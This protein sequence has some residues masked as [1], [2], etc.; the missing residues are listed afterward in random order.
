MSTE[1]KL[2]RDTFVARTEA[3]LRSMIFSGQ[4]RPGE[5]LNEVT[6]AATLGISRGP[7]REAVQRLG[8]QGILISQPHRGS[9]V[10]TFTRAEIVELYEM[11]SAVELQAVRV[12]SRA[13]GDEAVVHLRDLA[14][15]AHA[16]L[17]AAP[18]SP[19]PAD[20]DFHHQLVSLS[21]NTM[22]IRAAHDLQ[23]QIALARSMSASQPARAREASDEH[24][25]VV[26]AIA[27]H[28]AAAACDLMEHHIQ[29]SMQNA[30]AALG[31]DDQEENTRDI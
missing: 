3:V 2:D 1:I 13:G 28:D 10:R 15:R 12:L 26:D 24:D 21:G 5:R 27:R 22:L 29:H 18:G 11:R 17:S 20:L 6:L 23:L 25:A 16:V 19:F 30:L 9:F 4:I 7:L 14:T 8:G 31:V